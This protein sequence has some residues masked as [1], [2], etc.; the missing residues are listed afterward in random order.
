[1]LEALPFWQMVPS[2]QLLTSGTGYVLSKAGHVYV[3]YLPGGGSIDLDLTSNT[4]V[5]EATWFN[6][7]TGDSTEIGPVTGAPSR[8]SLHRTLSIGRFCS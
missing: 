2:N 4:N 8:H 5:F 3:C 1:M 7:R 6:P